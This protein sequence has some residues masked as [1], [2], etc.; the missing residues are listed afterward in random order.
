[1]VI[2]VQFVYSFIAILS[3][4][5]FTFMS[6]MLSLRSQSVILNSLGICRPC[7]RVVTWQHMDN[8]VLHQGAKLTYRNKEEMPF[9]TLYG[10]SYSYFVVLSQ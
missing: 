1:M 10:V 8:N 3:C 5:F 6:S 2:L 7:S 4:Q 9:W